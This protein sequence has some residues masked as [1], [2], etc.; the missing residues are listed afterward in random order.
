MK[1][2]AIPIVVFIG[3]ILIAQAA[4]FGQTPAP[5]AWQPYPTQPATAPMVTQ[6]AQTYPAAP[7]PA[8]AAPVPSPYYPVQPAVRQPASSPAEVGAPSRPF[9]TPCPPVGAAAMDCEQ[10]A[11]AMK[12]L[13]AV[14][15][16]IQEEIIWTKKVRKAGFN[17]AAIAGPVTIGV[18][19]PLAGAL[20]AVVDPTFLVL[21]VP[22]IV[23][24]VIG[25]GMMGTSANV[26]RLREEQTKILKDRYGM[27]WVGGNPDAPAIEMQ[28]LG[29]VGAGSPLGAPG[30]PG[31]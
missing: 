24:E 9:G 19:T 16:R 7:S 11:S 26:E 13:L 23:L 8:P 31:K 22:P 1:T 10:Y 27:P 2:K 18:F 4:A 28:Q 6:P 20:G 21:L 25:L 12:D 15:L 29:L 17:I 3:A 14:E 5:G 30:A